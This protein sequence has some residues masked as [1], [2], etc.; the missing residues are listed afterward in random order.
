MAVRTGV[1]RR[2]HVSAAVRTTSISALRESV[3]SVVSGEYRGTV[4]WRLVLLARKNG[5]V[6]SLGCGMSVKDNK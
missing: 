3:V 5:R 2:C 1:T 6:Y 4:L